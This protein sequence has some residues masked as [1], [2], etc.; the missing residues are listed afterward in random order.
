MKKIILFSMCIFTFAL[1]AQVAKIAAP[2]AENAWFIPTY[3]GVSTDTLGTVT[4]TT[5]SYAVPVN[6]F[7]GVFFA[8]QIK[9]ADK[10]T[11]AN[12]VCTVQPQGKYFESGTYTN[13]GSAITWTGIGSVDTTIQILSVSSK[14]YYPYIRA[15]VTNTSGKSK[16]VWYKFVI[17]R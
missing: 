4:A 13:I 12:G 8:L 11:G 1:N 14:V 9:L 5:W 3:T 17:K 2:L 7:D 6:K 15:V 10:T 16:V